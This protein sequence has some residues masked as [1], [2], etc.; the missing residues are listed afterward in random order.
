MLLKILR[1]ARNSSSFLRTRP[2]G[3]MKL[4]D[5]RK[6][7]AGRCFNFEDMLYAAHPDILP[8]EI[9]KLS[10]MATYLLARVRHPPLH[11]PEEQFVRCYLLICQQTLRPK[12]LY[13]KVFLPYTP[14]NVSLL[15][16]TFSVGYI[17]IVTV[18]SYLS[19]PYEL[20]LVVMF[21]LIAFSCVLRHN[22]LYTFLYQSSKSYLL[23][24]IFM[25]LL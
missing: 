7:L 10:E 24:Q 11:V 13:Q 2:K 20:G 17:Y 15:S 16:L 8:S 3:R 25:F 21:T 1:D 19:P 6:R 4:P 5:F 18:A 9:E 14:H 12:S 23:C 22:G